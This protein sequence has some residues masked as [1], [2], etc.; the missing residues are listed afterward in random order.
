MVSIT[1]FFKSYKSFLF[2]NFYYGS[3]GGIGASTTIF[4]AAV[5]LAGGGGGHG[6][7]GNGSGGNGGGGAGNGTSG[8]AN[9]G[10]GGGGFGGSG[11]SGVVVISV[12]T[13]SYT[14]TVT[15]APTVTINGA[16]TVMKF[17]TSGTY[18]A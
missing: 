6:Q 7:A 2:H 8:T 12:P 16:N 3:N 4:G 9:T 5:Y 13:A 18:L 11:G 17:T 15:G 10:G 1:I 14:G